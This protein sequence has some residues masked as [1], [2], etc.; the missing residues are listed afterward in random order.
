L[1]PYRLINALSYM[2]VASAAN[3]LYCALNRAAP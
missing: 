2:S 1:I 3:K